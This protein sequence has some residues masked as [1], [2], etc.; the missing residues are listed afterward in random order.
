MWALGCPVQK[1]SSLSLW[2]SGHLAEVFSCVY[3]LRHLLDDQMRIRTSYIV[4]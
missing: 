4:G 3:H 2:V 1:T